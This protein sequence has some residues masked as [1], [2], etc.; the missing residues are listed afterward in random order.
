MQIK[1]L[2]NYSFN[3]KTNTSQNII[4]TP[5]SFVQ[6][7]LASFV[8]GAIVIALRLFVAVV[9]SF[10]VYQLKLKDILPLI[11]PNSETLIQDL[12]RLGVIQQMFLIF[13]TSLI[14]GGMYYVV[15]FSCNLQATY[16][17]KL[18]AIKLIYKTTGGRVSFVRALVRYIAY[19]MPILFVFIVGIQYLNQSI[20]IFTLML[21]FLTAIW[22][23]V[24]F[25]IK[26]KSSIPDL[27][28]KTMLIST[29]AKF[30]TK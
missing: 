24:G 19:L 30:I 20:N 9:L 1:D 8:D 11:N 5:P 27:L 23:D 28:T 6:K 29:K 14:V 13:A 15:M 22:Y 16:G 10:I 18:F 25:F 7:F 3:Y 2:Q 4:Y 21:V 17:C 12:I 26:T